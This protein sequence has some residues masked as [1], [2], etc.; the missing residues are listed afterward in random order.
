MKKSVIK[1]VLLSIFFAIFMVTSIF[2]LALSNVL[3]KKAAKAETTWQTGVFEMDDGASLKLGEVGGLRFL[4]R[5][6]ETVKSFVVNT[7]DVEMGF[8]IAPK[9]LML[10]ANGDYLNMPKKIGGA[11]DKN[12][13]YQDGD[14]YFANGCITNIKAA[15][16]ERSFTAVAY[17]KQGETVRYTEYND[18][19]RNNLY[20]T[21]NMAVLDENE[22]YV[23]ILF[24]ESKA[25][26]YVQAGENE[27]WYGSEQYP[28]VV[29]NTTEYDKLVDIVNAA[30]IDFSGY[31]VVIKN[32]ATTNKV[33]TNTEIAPTI[34]SAALD[35]INKLIAALPDSVTMPDAIGMITRIREVEKKY[36]A[37][38][39]ADKA[40]VENYAKVENLLAAIE[41]YDRV[42]KN[43]ATD[44]TVIPSYVPN[45]TS[46]V[47]GTATTRTDDVYGNVLT[48]TSASDGK[49]ALHFTNFPSIEKY[50]KIYFYVKV[51]V[52]CNL[53][54]SDGITNDGWG[55][56][57][58]NNWSVDGYGCN[59]NTWRLVEIDPADGYIG[60]DFALG[61]KTETTG[62]T[63]EISD[64][65]GLQ[66][67]GSGHF[68]GVTEYSG[69]RNE[70]GGVYNI[71]REQYYIDK[72]DTATIGTFEQS[73]LAD[74][75]PSGYKYFYFWMYNPLTEA[76]VLKLEGNVGAGWVAAE[77]NVS[78]APQTW[79]K[80]VISEND[81][82]D[83]KNGT[84]YVYLENSDADGWQISP[85]Y[86]SAKMEVN[87]VFGVQADTG[88]TNENGKVYN[89]SR[90]QYYIDNNNT[91]TI[92]T[93][94][95]NKLAN[96]LPAGY[97]YFYFWMYNGTGTEYN[98]HLAG[99]CS[100]TWT[101][102]AD[103]VAL[104][105]GE[106]TKIIISATDI[107][108]NKQGQWYVYIL[109]GDGQGAAKDGWQISTIYAGF[110]GIKSDEG[111][112]ESEIVYLDHADVKEAIALIDA[113]PD[114]VTVADEA[115][116]QAARTAYD[117]LT[118]AQTSLVGNYTKLT[119]AEATLGDIKS[120]N[121][122]VAMIDAINANNID[123][124]KVTAARTA[125]D[126][127]TDSAKT[128]V[129]NLATLEGY[130]A[131][132]ASVEAA[133]KV[134]SMINALPDSVVMPDHLVFV[135]RIEAANAAYENLS[136]EAKAKITNYG[137]LRTLVSAIK[138]YETVYIQTVDGVSV[139]P[140]HVPNY[141]STIGGSASIGYDSYYGNYLK[142]TPE[143]GGRAA[144][145]FINFPDV[146]KYTK[147]YF[148]I[149]VVGASCDIY[150]SD[151]ITNDGWGDDWNNTWSTDGYWANNGN[152]IQK[153]IDLS[154]TYVSGTTTK[155]V[156]NIFASNWALGLRTS[157]TDV[158]FE[159]TNIIGVKPDLGKTANIS[160]GNFTDSGTT[161]EYGTV[162][163]LTQGWTGNDTDLGAFNIG[164]LSSALNEGH[165]ALRFYIYNPN[166][167]DVV[168]YVN[169][170]ETWIQT[171]LATLKTK[172][173]TEVVLTP[174]VIESNDTYLTYL[175]VRSGASTSGWQISPIYSFSVGDIV[176]K[177]QARIDALDTENLD[178]Y[179]VQLA[180]EAYEAL[181]ENQKTLVEVA[182]LTAC[183]EALYGE[184]ADAPFIVD[185]ATSSYKLYYIDD[186]KAA[187]SFVNEH[188]EAA[189]GVSIPV[190]GQKL[191]IT[192]YD[193]A[194]IFG[195]WDL[196]HS[197]DGQTQTAD[198]TSRADYV[199]EKMGRTVFILANSED[200]YRMAAL[201]L[202]RE[203][204]GYDMISEDCIAYESAK[205][206]TLPEFDIVG[207]P[208]D[209]RQKQ[210]YMTE[211]E[212]Y[213]MGLQSNSDLWIHSS[214]GWDMHNTLHYLPT[215]TYRSAHP[216]WYY[217]YTDSVN[218]SRTQI[219]PTAGGSSTEFNAMVAAIAENMLVR[220]N[221]FPERENISFSIMDTGDN[222][223]CTCA[224]CTLYDTLYGEGGFAAA[225]IDL[226]NAVN[227]KVRESLPEDRV[228]NIAFLAYRGT[229]KAPATIDADG[230]VTLLK[231]YEINDDGSYT[232]TSEDLK[233]DK[234]VMVWLAPI[235]G[236][237]AENL[238]HADNAETYAT[239]KK[240]CA[241]SGSVYLWLYGTN[242]KYYMYPYNTWQ[243][244]A[245]NYKILAELGVKGAWSQSNE[246]EA[247]AFSDLKGYI[248]SKFMA[249]VN[250]D[251]ETVLKTYFTNYFGP[252]AEK[253][254]SM[255]DA[256]V[257][258]CEAIEESNN[259]L[260]RG[261]YDELEY[262][263]GSWLWEEQHSYW[264]EEV[265]N[266]LV[267]LCDEAKAAV[268]ADTTLTDAQKTAIIS[269][270]TK[271]SLFPRYVL[272]TT[273]ASNY[274]S[275]DKKAMR[276]AFKADCEALGLTLYREAD[277]LLS[278]LYSDWGV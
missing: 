141:T 61:F 113:I 78:L 267:T 195:A 4:V 117:K 146:T 65:Y 252:A 1:N 185:G 202:L 24:G 25:G 124:A 276:Q 231:R 207:E 247:T 224:R 86:Y 162:Y 261:I 184:V 234:G 245:E 244:S 243:A 259:G 118:E 255:F 158:S 233:C 137:K 173:W 33:F 179:Q 150:L 232:Q 167:S 199:I 68:F 191:T 123:A 271:E 50:A 212:L 94:Q 239:V 41:G 155:Y 217:D 230:N 30:G 263:T 216:A 87:L 194:I 132:V 26:G 237:Y 183:E 73:E 16:L 3:P 203:L 22:N 23:D 228:L 27:G 241:I 220:I 8:V 88:T 102:S 136:D 186:A 266:N 175:C 189:T 11:I 121:E 143:A 139:I 140:S 108:L 60:T 21:V 80:V 135:S 226:M 165:D 103:T 210:T 7:E 6:D 105:V 274:S 107:E 93:L 221:M 13:I 170:N 37:L 2:G 20:D 19:A 53:Y 248:D 9:N 120:A 71:S 277:G 222:D 56:N 95:T 131:E 127:L 253:M 77:T 198:L 208:F 174:A 106:W 49:A 204:V 166:E 90:E 250:A 130:E 66:N 268:D 70:Y 142:V 213:G 148:N 89:I 215:E 104:K 151:G 260:G 40:A 63:F 44:G 57:W 134:I 109:G 42:Y 114:T 275:S 129:T 5:M 154:G 196:Y 10:E 168:F 273:Y 133:N 145:Q 270:I 200:G 110:E 236:L 101:D 96:A 138:G 180:R 177:V 172:A 242:F 111:T 74:N 156:R 43:D 116:I 46:T 35:E 36:N 149:R 55:I 29:E 153:E 12:K 272:C 54:L 197:L 38:G 178:E 128:L 256:I 225:W 257:A 176:D 251:Y 205:A 152:W 157:T 122:V 28:I 82:E 45:N 67:G 34:I 115:A 52:A 91:N 48:V 265:L 254:R 206:A 126:N 193:Y 47:G 75:L 144:I 85:L 219:C 125:Y 227:A 64:F 171:E 76:K 238:N 100:G 278:D 161:N 211:T 99:D 39:E 246:T 119:A 59:A 192:K 98:F 269:R 81:I 164:V 83:N 62:F 201:A 58:K 169:E 249:D 72:N 262:T 223:D 190:V 258:N 15:N 235:N 51:S 187:A 240:W 17:I 112:A 97:E 181:T 163:N 14:Y 84:W 182:N 188:I 147:L 18:L 32:E 92:G 79:T 69:E 159:I 160:F 31:Y 264:T 214:E 218:V 209:Y 229:E